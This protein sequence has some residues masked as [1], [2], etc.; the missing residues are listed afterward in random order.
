MNHYW[1][2]PPD[3]GNDFC[4]VCGNSIDNC[5]CPECP[6]CGSSGDPKCYPA[7]MTKS[8]EQIES[9]ARNLALWEE[10][11]R[12]ENEMPRYLADERE[13]EPQ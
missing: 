7:H 2:E 10:Q 5:I 12:I 13:T 11:N 8:G 1:I 6:V 3:Q 9:Y 4:D